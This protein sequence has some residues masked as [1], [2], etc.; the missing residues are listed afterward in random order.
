MIIIIN[1]NKG[2]TRYRQGMD[3]D[4]RYPYWA[5]TR[6]HTSIEYLWRPLILKAIKTSAELDLLASSCCY[7]AA[8]SHRSESL[9]A[10]RPAQTIP[11]RKH[12]GWNSH[13][14]LGV[15]EI[16]WHKQRQ[17][18]LCRIQNLK[19]VA[20]I[21]VIGNIRSISEPLPVLAK[22]AAGLI[23]KKDTTRQHRWLNGSQFAHH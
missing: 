22:R 5:D 3:T 8:V 20:V 19:E 9:C 16:F 4:T 18:K 1:N 15:L 6:L 14:N 17:T 13:Q 7:T 12:G 10:S 23:S 21:P 11:R 2:W